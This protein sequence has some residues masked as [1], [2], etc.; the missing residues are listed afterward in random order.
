MG[1]LSL[2]DPAQIMPV[3]SK[4]KTQNGEYQLADTICRSLQ[5]FLY[6]IGKGKLPRD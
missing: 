4:M 6:N 3:L 1:L 2:S 5:A